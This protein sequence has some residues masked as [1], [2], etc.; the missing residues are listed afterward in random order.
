[1]SRDIPEIR[2]PFRISRDTVTIVFDC[3]MRLAVLAPAGDDNGFG[4]GVNAVL[5]EFRDGL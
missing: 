5:D 1:V 3:Q 2:Q 4:M